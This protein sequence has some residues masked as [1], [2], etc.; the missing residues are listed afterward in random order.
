MEYLLAVE[1]RFDRPASRKGGLLLVMTQRSPALV[2]DWLSTLV[3]SVFHFFQALRPAR[4]Y[5]AKLIGRQL[6]MTHIGTS[7][8]CT[9]GI[10]VS[11]A[12]TWHPTQA[13]LNS[14]LTTLDY[15]RQAL[16]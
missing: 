14:R 8:V 10:G 16:L 15:K 6:C 9:N 1:T 11:G 3:V 4:A 7:S 13:P 5:Y 2:S 12:T